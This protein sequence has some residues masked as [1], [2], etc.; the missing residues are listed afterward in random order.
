VA[1]STLLKI[2]SYTPDSGYVSLWLCLVDGAAQQ[3][4]AFGEPT[5]KSAEDL[6]AK[7]EHLPGV[8]VLRE[9]M[10]YSMGTRRM[11]KCPT[12]QPETQPA[13]AP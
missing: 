3:N 11:W 10:P 5:R 9:T 13:E 2:R 12:C 7:M 4:L 6:A 8:K 1:I